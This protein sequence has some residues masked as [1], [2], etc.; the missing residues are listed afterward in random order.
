MAEKILIIDDEVRIHHLLTLYLAQHHYEVVT[1]ENGEKG[2]RQA[3]LHAPDLIVL[4]MVMPG[5]DGIEVCRALRREWGV[6]V[7]F[8]S[9]DHDPDRMAEA[10]EAGGDEYL[11]KPFDPNELVSIIQALLGRDRTQAAEK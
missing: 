3:A 2:L 4:D 11:T 5:M 10:M 1:A 7:V 8:M 9:G 6:P